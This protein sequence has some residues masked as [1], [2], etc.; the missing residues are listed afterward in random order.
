MLSSRDLALVTIL[1]SL[2]FVSAAAI[3]QLGYLI[4]G[5]N[6]IGYVY[7]IILATQTSLALLIYEGRRWRFLAQMTLFTLLTIPTP[8]GGAPFDALGKLSYVITALLTDILSNSIHPLFNRAQ[9]LLYWS[10]FNGLFFWILKPFISIITFNL[11]YA[12]EFAVTFSSVVV[13]LLPVIIAQSSAGGYLGFEIYRRLNK[14][15]LR[16][17]QSYIAPVTLYFL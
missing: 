15:K 17:Q 16:I 14:D 13:I 5:I 3:A 6:G 11:F 10:I 8:I 7:T 9:R 2:C 4:T 1:A 12:P